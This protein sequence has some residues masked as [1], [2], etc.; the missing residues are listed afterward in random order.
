MTLYI[1]IL[2]GSVI[3]INQ[4]C[5]I[6]LF[7]LCHLLFLI[8]LA[9]FSVFLWSK[10]CMPLSA[11]GGSLLVCFHDLF[12][13]EVKKNQDAS[14]SPGDTNANHSISMNDS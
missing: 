1:F 3:S 4:L 9:Y 11:G 5:F 13:C 8:I 10:L 12:F 2:S 6:Y 7:L 14:D